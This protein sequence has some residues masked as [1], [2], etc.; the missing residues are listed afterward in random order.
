MKKIRKEINEIGVRKT[1][2]GIYNTK[3]DSY[4]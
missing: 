2:Q 1:I 3:I 4:N